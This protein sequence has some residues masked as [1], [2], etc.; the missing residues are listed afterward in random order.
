M[1]KRGRGQVKNQKALVGRAQ[2]DQSAPIPGER[3]RASLREEEEDCIDS[4]LPDR[5]PSEGPRSSA[6]N[7]KPN[8]GR[9]IIGRDRQQHANPCSK[10][11]GHINSGEGREE[12]DE[13]HEDRKE[14]M[15]LIEILALLT[16]ERLGE[17]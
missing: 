4:L 3:Y 9:Q 2:E 5:A 7:L 17:G 13:N 15:A 14:P 10:Q 6:T 11:P 1:K 12:H 16:A 8:I